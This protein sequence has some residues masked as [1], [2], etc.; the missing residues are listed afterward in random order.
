MEETTP[1]IGAEAFD[2]QDIEKNKIWGVLAYFIF[3]LPL[4]AA[5]DSPFAK[6]HANQALCLFLLAVANIIVG[7]I[8]FLGWIINIVV[9]IAIIVF[10]IIGIINAAGGKAKPLPLIGG[11]SIIK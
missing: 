1:N 2:P 11:F 5:P 10:L 7:F 4:L 8:P 6:Y 3:F 9:G